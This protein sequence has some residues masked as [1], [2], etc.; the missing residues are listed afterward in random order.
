MNIL[1]LNTNPLNTNP[2]NSPSLKNCPL[3]TSLLNTCLLN[4][5][6]YDI[7]NIILSLLNDTDLLMLKHCNKFYNSFII[8]KLIV[9]S[10]IVAES[11]SQKVLEYILSC[12]CP[13]TSWTYAYAAKIGNLPMLQ[14][15]VNRYWFQWDEWTIMLAV[16]EFQQKCFEW[17]IANDHTICMHGHKTY[18]IA[19]KVNNNKVLSWYNDNYGSEYFDLLSE[20]AEKG[21]LTEIKWLISKGFVLNKNDIYEPVLKHD[22][23]HIFK[24]LVKND[25]LYWKNNSID[26]IAA[27][28]GSI[29]ILKW[30]KDH[31]YSFDENTCSS[32]ALGGQLE[33]L[34]W[35]RSI[36]CQWTSS[37]NINAALCG[38]LHVLN[39]ATNN[40]CPITKEICRTVVESR[41]LDI[42]K[43]CVNNNYPIDIRQCRIIARR[44]HDNKILSWLH[45]Y[46]NMSFIKKI[47]NPFE[48]N[49]SFMYGFV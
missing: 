29:K 21:R 28:Y 39:W 6:P 7:Q 43:W 45:Q 19:K 27:R 3:N 37:T 22:H 44:N 32:A 20:A 34:K 25:K 38:H 33:T 41:N 42:L 4:T 30:L 18:F 8:K 31:N 49:L 5:C 48:W 2:L 15:L 16:G 24:W 47:L 10:D 35:L 13:V 11:S 12:G 9:S 1:P 36:N 46:E 23:L 26:I 17:A 14:W 40:G